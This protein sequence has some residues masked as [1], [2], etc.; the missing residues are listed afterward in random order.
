[1]KRV[2][3]CALDW[4]LGHAARCVPIVEMLQQYGHE[5]VI[6][7]SGAAGVLLKKEFPG[8]SYTELPGYNPVYPSGGSMITKMLLQ[9]PHFMRVMRQEHTL[10]EAMVEKFKPDVV[11]SDNRY[12]CYSRTI[13]SIFISHQL[14][15][16]LPA[17]WA[18]CEPAFNRLLQR[19]IRRFGEVWVPDQ[20]NSGLTEHFMSKEVPF[21]FVGWLSRFRRSAQVAKKYDVMAIVSGPEPQRTM[22]EKILR[23]QLSG[24]GIRAMLVTGQPGLEERISDGSLDIV[25]HLTSRDM[26]TAVLSSDVIVSRS[27]YSTVM[28]LIALRKKA[29]FVPTPHQNEQI[30]LGKVLQMQGVASCTDQENFV[31]ESALKGALEFKGLGAFSWHPGLL[32]EQ[33]KRL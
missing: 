32:E 12:G 29:V 25:S 15:V 27:G 23:R 14:H 18:W 22:F 2:L 16:Y 17:G 6:A 19:L 11:I 21:K 24:K 3:I 13:R 8:C 31:L 28:D 33:I 10:V 9:L 30:F 7:S 26:E 1:M 5:V 20:P 4:G